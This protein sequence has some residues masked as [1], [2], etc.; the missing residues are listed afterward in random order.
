MNVEFEQ[1]LA[2]QYTEHGFNLR[3]LCNINPGV[4]M[5]TIRAAL[6]HQG[7]KI[8]H[9]GFQ[10]RKTREGEMNGKSRKNPL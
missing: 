9:K 2:R 3:D 1:K 4:N 6:I 8:K 10:F 7:I 5:D